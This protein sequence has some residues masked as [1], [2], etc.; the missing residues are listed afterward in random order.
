MSTRHTVIGAL[1]AGA[2]VNG[3]HSLADR[4]STAYQRLVSTIEAEEGFR[5]TCYADSLGVETIAYGV[6]IPLTKTE[7]AAILEGRLQEKEDELRAAWPPYDSQIIEVQAALLDLSYQVGAEGVLGF[8]KMLSALD[9]YDYATAAA[10][11]ID[12]RLDHQTPRRAERVAA[13]F[14]GIR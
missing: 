4:D 13:V 3:G 5:G 8:K 7:G 1:L 2:F 9:R 14:R 11:V 6:R 12:S 10:E